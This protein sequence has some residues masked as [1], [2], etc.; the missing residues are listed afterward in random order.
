MTE[1]EMADK[2]LS[3]VSEQRTDEVISAIIMATAIIVKSCI[4]KDRMEE[5]AEKFK[6]ALIGAIK[7]AN[8]KIAIIKMK[9][10]G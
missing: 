10:N 1:K 3:F 7:M 2:I 8:V 9:E 4:D 6:I 5:F